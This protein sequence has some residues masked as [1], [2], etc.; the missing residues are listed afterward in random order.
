MK[1]FGAEDSRALERRLGDAYEVNG[2]TAWSLLSKTERFRV[3]IV[4]DLSEEQTRAMR[5]TKVNS[6]TE[7]LANLPA[8]ATGYLMP[9]GPALLPVA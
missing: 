8:S 1:W 2:Q 6:I 4:T 5:M 7:A 3:H 9:R